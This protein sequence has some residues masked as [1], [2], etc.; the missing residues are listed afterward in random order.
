MDPSVW[1]NLPMELVLMIAKVQ[2]APGIQSR[3]GALLATSTAQSAEGLRSLYKFCLVSKLMRN[4]LQPLLY[5]EC[6]FQTFE[7][8][9]SFVDTIIKRPDLAARIKRA[10]VHPKVFVHHELWTTLQLVVK[11]E[12]ALGCNIFSGAL[13]LDGP[14]VA[15]SYLPWALCGLMPN[16][17]HMVYHLPDTSGRNWYFHPKHI[18]FPSAGDWL[19]A[20]GAIENSW[21]L[22][23]TRYINHFPSTMMNNRSFLDHLA[24]LRELHSQTRGN[25]IL[26]HPQVYYHHLE[27]QLRH[28]A[29]RNGVLDLPESATPTLWSFPKLRHLELVSLD[30][31]QGLPSWF[32]HHL[33]GRACQL[34]TL[35]IRKPHEVHEEVVS[36][37]RNL[38]ASES[39]W[40]AASPF[41]SVTDLRI[42]GG[43]NH[44]NRELAQLFSPHRLHLISALHPYFRPSHDMTAWMNSP[45]LTHLHLDC[46]ELTMPGMKDAVRILRRTLKQFTTLETLVIPALAL[47]SLTSEE[48]YAQEYS[49]ASQWLRYQ[50][51]AEY[52]S[53]WQVIPS[54]SNVDSFAR[55]LPPTLRGLEIIRAASVPSF[56]GSAWCSFRQ[57]V[58]KGVMPNLKWI[59]CDDSRHFK[60]AGL[61]ERFASLGVEFSIVA[62]APSRP[63]SRG[64]FSGLCELSRPRWPQ[65]ESSGIML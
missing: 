32:P 3:P 45:N 31:S 21:E 50:R 11:I 16:L 33:P 58:E 49:T 42:V 26:N 56:D 41:A 63:T 30:W 62:A 29:L 36:W 65:D 52:T 28:R 1:G 24:E 59:R 51:A 47:A 55:L 61:Q 17:E 57:D 54:P 14:D 15:A 5:Q 64:D 39:T 7:P 40:P 60:A 18:R 48:V 6:A 38:G 27:L 19:S 22:N 23:S 10:Y 13:G 9:K 34:T 2:Y 37:S 43:Q 8:L 53:R 44:D 20:A 25:N 46:N 4:T 12:A 35:T